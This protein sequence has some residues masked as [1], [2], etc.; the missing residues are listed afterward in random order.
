MQR[1]FLFN[2]SYSTGT[3]YAILCNYK[4]DFKKSIGVSIF[5]ERYVI[6]SSFL[7]RICYTDK[8][9]RQKIVGLLLGKN[10]KNSVQKIL[11]RHARLD[12]HNSLISKQK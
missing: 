1:I 6:S 3:S 12:F 2:A 9:F 5:D 11:D 8:Q 4:S 10:K 7:L